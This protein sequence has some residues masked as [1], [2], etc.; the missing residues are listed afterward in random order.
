MLVEIDNTSA[1]CSNSMADEMVEHIFAQQYIIGHF[2]KANQLQPQDPETTTSTYTNI[3][4]CLHLSDA[5]PHID[6]D[7]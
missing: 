3:Y 7:V 4:I 2:I 6:I 1:Q 5:N